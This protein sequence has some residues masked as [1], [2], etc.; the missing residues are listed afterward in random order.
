MPSAVSLV[1]RCMDSTALAVSLWTSLIHLG[2]AFRCLAR[3]LGQVLDLFC[4]H[5]KSASLF[6]C[7]GRLDGGVKC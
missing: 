5:R 3:V 7:P 2:D 1:P 4:D 6:P